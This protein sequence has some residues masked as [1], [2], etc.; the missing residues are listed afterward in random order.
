MNKIKFEVTRDTYEITSFKATTGDGFV[1]IFDVRE[2]QTHCTAYSFSDKIDIPEAYGAYGCNGPEYTG[3]W[4]LSKIIS[5][6]GKELKFE[7]ES[8]VQAHYEILGQHMRYVLDKSQ[9]YTL[10][11]ETK[12]VLNPK[13]LL[14]LCM[15]N[16]LIRLLAM[17]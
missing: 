17:V 15:Q 16:E 5:P 4:Y 11:V 1:Y 14:I 10:G 7:Y 9:T 12:K 8:Y 3:S 6:T 13:Q 2:R